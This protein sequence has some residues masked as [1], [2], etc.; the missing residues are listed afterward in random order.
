MLHLSF[1]PALHCS[2]IRAHIISESLCHFFKARY[3]KVHNSG[4]PMYILTPYIPRQRQTANVQT[5][6][7]WEVMASGPV[8]LRLCSEV[9]L[10]VDLPNAAP[11][12]QP[13]TDEAMSVVCGHCA[14]GRRHHLHSSLHGLG[15]HWVVRYFE[16]NL[17]YAF[18]LR[19]RQ[20]SGERRLRDVFFLPADETLLVCG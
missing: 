8:S 3:K 9:P 2:L 5:F 13:G 10:G 12:L 6:E 17:D 1:T 7:H 15:V 4:G 19:I 20:P 18:D 11:M 14:R 16:W